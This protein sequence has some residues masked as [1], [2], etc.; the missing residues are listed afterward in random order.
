MVH[1][2]KALGADGIQTIMGTPNIRRQKLPIQKKAKKSKKI[3]QRSRIHV[4]K[5]QFNINSMKL[6]YP[7]GEESGNF[8]IQMISTCRPSR[9]GRGW[10]SAP[11]RRTK[12]F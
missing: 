12:R 3:A 9:R 1:M 4:K 5:S 8:L 2:Q 6:V 11:V 7:I 10:G